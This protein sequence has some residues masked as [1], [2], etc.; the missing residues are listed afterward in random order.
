[1]NIEP[2]LWLGAAIGAAIGFFKK[3]TFFKSL[4]GAFDGCVVGA[5]VYGL[6][7]GIEHSILLHPT[8]TIAGSSVVLV[9]IAAFAAFR[10]RP[11]PSGPISKGG[12]F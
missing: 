7:L 10:R 12:A 11:P 9:G 3:G 2:F 5:A 4:S 6:V 8:E 1:M